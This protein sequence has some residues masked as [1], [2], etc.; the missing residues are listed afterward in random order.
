MRLKSVLAMM[1]IG[2]LFSYSTLIFAESNEDPY[3]N[4]NRAMFSF[5]DV[6]D[7]FVLKPVATIYEKIVPKPL[8]KGFSNIY[9]NIDTVP[10]I[11]NDVLQGNLYQAT[12]DTWR[13]AINSTIGIGGFFDPASQIGLEANTEDFGLTLAQW[14]YTKSNFLV[15][16]FMGPTTFRDGISYPVNYYYMSLYPY[17]RPTS[18]QYAWYFGGVIVRRADLLEYEN[19][20]QQAAIDKYVFIRDAYLQHR[21][22]LIERNNQLG[23]PY[24]AENQ[25]EQNTTDNQTSNIAQNEVCPSK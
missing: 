18:A 21:N 13:F 1:T 10:T 2:I 11:I 24:V 20:M 15:L 23:N 12:S 14:G 19:F 22:Y 7:R 25:L 9:A 16:P 5:N 6:L 17:I 4:F 3:E 8:A